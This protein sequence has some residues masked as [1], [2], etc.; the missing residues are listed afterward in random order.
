MD[1]FALLDELE[2]EIENSKKM[3]LSA[4]IVIDRELLLNYID[5]IRSELPEE[6]RQARWIVRER[7]RVINEAKIEAE[8]I[9][10][11]AK[12]TL[13]K[14]AQESEVVREAKIH[15]EEIIAEAHK[16][17]YE[18]KSSAHQYTDELL[19]SVETRLQKSLNLIKEGREELQ[20]RISKNGNNVKDGEAI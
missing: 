17:S 3:P 2:H 1:M 19:A 16:I 15:G 10:N 13:K 20:A 7:E 9:I 11:E 8:K 5:K 6:M 18:I 4:K 14:M 12:L